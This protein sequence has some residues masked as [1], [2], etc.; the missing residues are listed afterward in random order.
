MLPGLESPSAGGGGGATRAD[1]RGKAAAVETTIAVA[2]TA[3]VVELA[4]VTGPP[5]T[6]DD[7]RIGLPES[8]AGKTVYV[9]DSFSLIFQVFHA[10]PEMTGPRGEPVGAV[11][12]LHARHARLA[13][14]TEARLSV[15]RVRFAG[16][17]V[18]HELFDQYKAHRTEMPPD[19]RPQIGSIRRVLEAMEIP[20]LGSPGLRGRRH[21]GHGRP[22]GTTSA[23]A[24]AFWFGRQG[25][26]AVDH[27]PGEDFQ[28]PQESGVR[29]RG[30]GGRLGRPARIRSSIFRRWLATR[31]TMCRACR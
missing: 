16:A 3:A 31:S 9:V 21:V 18:P 2:T 29:R 5:P 24:N 15:L 11:L 7:A 22:A 14:A 17:D 4:S 6:S 27:R 12:R 1:G 10:Y 26:P 28:H 23:A 19:L 30:A 25:L 20:V 13:G 8:L